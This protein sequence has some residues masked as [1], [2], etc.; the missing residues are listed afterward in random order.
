MKLVKYISLFLFTPYHFVVVFLYL[1]PVNL[2]PHW[3]SRYCD[4]HEE[5]TLQPDQGRPG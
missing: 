2:N 3:A 1:N 4:I 5:S